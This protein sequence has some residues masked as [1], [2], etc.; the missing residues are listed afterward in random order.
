MPACATD[1]NQLHEL[2]AAVG[3]QRS[4][5]TVA[6]GTVDHVVEVA[7]DHLADVFRLHEIFYCRDGGRG[8]DPLQPLRGH[9]HLGA[10][11]L[12]AQRIGLAV[13]IGCRDIVQ[14]NEGQAT[15]CAARQCLGGPGAHSA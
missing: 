7:D 9:C 3:N 1:G 13:D 11:E 14:V 12:T 15:H 6:I 8:I 4:L 5:D 2:L 10:A